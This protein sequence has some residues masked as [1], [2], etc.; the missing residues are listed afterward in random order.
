MEKFSAMH[1]RCA[2]MVVPHSEAEISKNYCAANLGSPE[3]ELRFCP[4]LILYCSNTEL[5]GL[6]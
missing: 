2:V 6:T 4:W 3:V 5:G 1:F